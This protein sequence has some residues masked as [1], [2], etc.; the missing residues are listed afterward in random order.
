MTN[1]SLLEQ[2]LKL[3]ANERAEVAQQVLLSLEPAEFCDDVDHAWVAEIQQ[4]RAA[5][6]NGE[7][8]LL[9]W[10]DV[11]RQI[12]GELGQARSQ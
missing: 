1:E 5:I 12:L 11:R 3:P 6:R 10:A 9:E 4:R 2:V 7:V 8:Q